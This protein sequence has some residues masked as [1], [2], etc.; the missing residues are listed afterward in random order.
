M[1]CYGSKTLNRTHTHTR[2]HLFWKCI[3]NTHNKII[4]FLI[5]QSTLLTSISFLT[6]HQ[7]KTRFPSLWHSNVITM[8]PFS[9]TFPPRLSWVSLNTIPCLFLAKSLFCDDYSFC[10]EGSLLEWEAQIRSPPS[11][12]KNL[13]M[14][15]SNSFPPYLLN[16]YCTVCTTFIRLTL[17]SNCFTGFS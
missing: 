2:T 14:G 1:S 11:P 17:F 3:I 16:S 8:L 5:S 15:Y 4:A 10:V 9:A 13:S 7:I 12:G 6:L